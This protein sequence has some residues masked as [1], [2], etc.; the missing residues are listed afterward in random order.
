MTIKTA[1]DEAFAEIERK[2]AES[3]LSAADFLRAGLGHMEDRAATYDQPSGERSMSKTVA[4]FNA[5]NGTALTAEQGWQFMALLKIARATQGD[6]RA[7]NYED[8]AAYA[9]LMGE[10]AGEARHAE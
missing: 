4:A 10:S 6:F 3:K 8:L 2:Q 1:E 9:G 5:L 7:D